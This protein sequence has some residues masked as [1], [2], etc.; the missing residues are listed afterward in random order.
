VTLHAGPISARLTYRWLRRQPRSSGDRYLEVAWNGELDDDTS[1]ALLAVD[2]QCKTIDAETPG[3]L[4]VRT[5]SSRGRPHHRKVARLMARLL[6]TAA[7][8]G[9]AMT[10]RV[11]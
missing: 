9:I 7:R 10:V 11:Y 6:R 1:E 2:L 3:R 4:R 5:R 8:S